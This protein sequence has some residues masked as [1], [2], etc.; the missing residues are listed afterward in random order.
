MSK[1]IEP[2]P[3][4]LP[5]KVRFVIH[6]HTG[7]GEPHFDVM[8]D[9]PA[10]DG[11]ATWRSETWPLVDR[12]ELVALAPHRLEYLDHEGP[13]RSGKGEVKRVTRGE[14]DVEDDLVRFEAGGPW[15]RLGARSVVVE[16]PR[17]PEAD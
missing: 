3:L 12:G 17:E 6:Y 4:S 13:T 9:L 14:C 15:W 10:A 11:L 2:P 8:I 7:Y 1:S 16:S 5:V